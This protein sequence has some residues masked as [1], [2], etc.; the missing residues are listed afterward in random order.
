MKAENSVAS[1]TS[2]ELTLLPGQ[3]QTL[4]DTD[5][6]SPPFFSPVSHSNKA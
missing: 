2:E 4:I 1:M 6:A 3:Q 5:P